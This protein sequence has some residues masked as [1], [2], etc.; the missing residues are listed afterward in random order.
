M[1]NLTSAVRSVLTQY[2]TFSGRASRSELWWWVLALIIVLIGTQIVDAFAITPLLGFDFG[3]ANSG[4]PLSWLVSLAVL[5]PNIAVGVRRL[6][7]TD[8]SGWWILIGF[9]P[10]VGALVLLFFYVSAGTDGS[11]RFGPKPNWPPMD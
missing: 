5:L 8:R 6:H 9:V 2:A 4:Q 3:D 10:V 7:D 11:N 1:E